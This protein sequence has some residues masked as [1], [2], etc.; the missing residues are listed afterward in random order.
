[1][2]KILKPLMMTAVVGCAVLLTST[3]LLAKNEVKVNEKKEKKEKKEKVKKVAVQKGWYI[4][5][6]AQNGDTT[7]N[8]TVF[9][10]LQGASDGKD[11]YDAEAL[12]A[13]GSKHFY[14]TIHHDDFAGADEYRS[15]YRA[16]AKIGKKSDTWVII[17]HSGNTAADVTLSWNGVTEGKKVDNGA[18]IEKHTKGKKTLR[19]MR[20]IDEENGEVIEV[21]KQRSYTFNMNGKKEH[22]LKWMLLKNGEDEP[23]LEVTAEM[24]ETSFKVEEAQEAEAAEE[25]LPPSVKKKHKK[26]D[27]KRKTIKRKS[28]TQN[29]KKQKQNDKKKQGGRLASPEL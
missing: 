29:D 21:K 19:R 22:Q 11:R 20:L 7:N 12:S 14:T 25:S 2:K 24:S 13:G 28:K 5:L 27:E 9:G 15:D 26:T 23:V 1:M 10:Y 6:T 3:P 18:F 4:R 16:Y 8:T 17:V